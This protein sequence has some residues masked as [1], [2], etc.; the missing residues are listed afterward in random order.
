MVEKTHLCGKAP[1]NQLSSPATPTHLT[2]LTS[3][4]PMSFPTCASGMRT[5]AAVLPVP[6]PP[7]PSL[8]VSGLSPMLHVPSTGEGEEGRW[9]IPGLSR[10]LRS[11]V[12]VEPAGLAATTAIRLSVNFAWN[13]QSGTGTEVVLRELREFPMDAGGC[14][15]PFPPLPAQP[16]SCSNPAVVKEP[17]V[18][19]GRR[20]D[21]FC[22]HDFRRSN[23]R[24]IPRPPHPWLL[25]AAACSFH[26]AG[27][28]PQHGK[29][30]L[31]RLLLLLGGQLP[32]PHA[33]NQGKGRRGHAVGPTETP[34]DQP[35]NQPN[36][37]G[38]QVPGFSTLLPGP[39]PNL[40]PPCFLVLL[41]RYV[42]PPR[43]LP[44][45]PSSNSSTESTTHPYTSIHST[46][47]THRHSPY[48]SIAGKKHTDASMQGTRGKLKIRD[49]RLDQTNQRITNQQHH[50]T[51]PSRCRCRCSHGQNP[52]NPVP[53][54]EP[55]RVLTGRPANLVCNRIPLAPRRPHIHRPQRDQPT[56]G[57]HR[58]RERS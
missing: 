52:T 31:W 14:L 15:P 1:S 34:T 51:G 56:Q 20:G 21:D 53:Q 49:S 4:P 28:P 11:L 45:A 41:A 37:P 18:K 42:A 22:R 6:P 3:K 33:P 50:T 5:S 32:T 57:G 38:A 27:S 29:L 9:I 23:K 13:G 8:V 16:V 47:C 10:R 2:S 35:T 26:T 55:P 25:P 24:Y 39:G 43:P 40:P 12:A 48:H 54:T 36:G 17:G 44:L 7:L 19:R 58:L 46:Q 30:A